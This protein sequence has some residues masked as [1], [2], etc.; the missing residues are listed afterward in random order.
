MERLEVGSLGTVM[1]GSGSGHQDL[2][3]VVDVGGFDYR[4][5]LPGETPTGDEGLVLREGDVFGTL[6]WE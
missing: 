1:Q 6:E 2:L 4:W 3:S 5:F